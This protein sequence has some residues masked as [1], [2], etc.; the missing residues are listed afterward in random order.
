MKILDSACYDPRLLREGLEPVV[1]FHVA[2]PNDPGTKLLVAGTES[3]FHYLAQLY[4]AIKR[5]TRDVVELHDFHLAIAR[6][7]VKHMED[8][9]SKVIQNGK[10]TL[11]TVEET[12]EERL[13]EEKKGEII[14]H[15]SLPITLLP[16]KPNDWQRK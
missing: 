5:D 16:G 2:N 10:Q 15:L 3:A 14:I 6:R 9:W 12:Y 13:K 1:P 7:E 4:L 8:L 11:K